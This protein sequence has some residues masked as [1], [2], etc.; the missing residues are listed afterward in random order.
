MDTL[1]CLTAAATVLSLLGCGTQAK[2]AAQI[3]KEVL[4]ERSESWDG[5]PYTAYPSGPPQLTLIRLKI[6]ARTQ[7]P[8][9]THP[10]PNAAYIVSGELT[11][12]T[13]AN[14]ASRTLRQGQT[15]AE[16]VGT[17]HRGITGN[18]PVELLVFYA[19]TPGMPLSE[20]R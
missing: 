17:E 20:Q 12:E 16:M 3:E 13:R 15:L 11:V 1:K 9:H 4:L 6:P 5:T 19:G 2:D 10:M 14:G 7:L 18:T 8:W